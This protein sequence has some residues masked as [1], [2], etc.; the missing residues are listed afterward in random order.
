[1]NYLFIFLLL[2]PVKMLLKLMQRPTGKKLVIQTAKIGDFVNITPLLRHLGVSDA[3]LSRTVQ[4]LAERDNTL[5]ECLYIED[6][7]QN[8]FSK[9]RLGLRLVNRYSHVYLLHPNNS[10]LFFAALCNAPDKQFLSTYTR[11]WY[12]KLFYLTASGVVEHRR[13]TLTLQNYLRLA[14][15][16][17]TWRSQ[18]KH[19]TSPLW[20]PLTP[21]PELATSTDTLNIG[22]SISAGNKAK[23]LPPS[24]WGDIFT[25]L[26]SL[27]CRYYVFGP[28]SEQGYLDAL[29]RHAG[30]E[31]DI[32]SLIGL[33][34]LQDVP[35]A[36]R[37]MDCYIATDS[38]NV[39]I[40]DAL[41]V[42]VICFAGPC[43]AKEQLPLNKA[44]I[45]R[46]ESIPPSSFVF[47]ALYHF[48]HP[49]TELYALTPEDRENIYH[50]VG[51]LPASQRLTA[52]RSDISAP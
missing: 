45:I 20:R 1:M 19:A 5:A 43:E 28:A 23:T 46:P 22:I 47:A 8:L 25:L 35:D 37:R 48:A 9:I 4:P 10:N 31:A 26:A 40:A 21:R 18:P 50:F 29:V 41:Q 42:P 44:L 11:R 17:L 38:G 52:R 15:R 14:D 6:Y 2:L 34:P 16:S 36:I 33:L 49:A 12:H 13:D 27:P 51:G 30:A 7:K 3:L 24:V 32:V 39:Y